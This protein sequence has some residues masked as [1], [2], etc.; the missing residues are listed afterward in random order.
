MGWD[1]SNRKPGMTTRAYFERE[2]GHG[3]PE[4]KTEFVGTA[5]VGATFYA[6]VRELATGK[7]FA[8]VCL[9]QRQRGYFNFGY[10]SMDENMGPNEA[11]MPPKLLD[12]L[13]PTDHEYATEWRYQCRL[14]A[15]K[16]A[17]AAAAPYGTHIR[18]SRPVK[19]SGKLFVTDF[20]I[21]N[22]KAGRMVALAPLGRKFQCGLGADW[23]T[24]YNWKKV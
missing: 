5:M 9:T 24:R 10:K 1:W 22:A 3:T 6:A 21:H 8:L 20:L 23:A 19:F 17:L 12:M 14:N 13:T 2:F 11:E 15:E 18:L 7:V 4:A 16:K